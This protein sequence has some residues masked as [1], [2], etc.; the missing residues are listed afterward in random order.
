MNGLP[1]TKAG[2]GLPDGTSEIADRGGRPGKR[3]TATL[4][5]VDQRAG[6]MFGLLDGRKERN[7]IQMLRTIG[8]VFGPQSAEMALHTVAIIRSPEIFQVQDQPNLKTGIGEAKSDRTRPTLLHRQ[9]KIWVIVM[10]KHCPD[11]VFALE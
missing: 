7:A 1:T 5:V 10:I 2:G 8:I 4:V 3:I 6:T 11:L 9:R